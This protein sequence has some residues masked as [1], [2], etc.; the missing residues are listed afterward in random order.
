MPVHHPGSHS[1]GAPASRVLGSGRARRLCWRGGGR[2]VPL[3]GVPG[4]YWVSW[5]YLTYTAAGGVYGMWDVDD[6]PRD[7]RAAL[8][9][10]FV[11]VAAS[12]AMYKAAAVLGG[13][14]PS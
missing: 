4:R 1:G 9:L 13:T 7:G 14:T 11:L 2:E 5:V 6:W 3:S 8:A 10:G 12:Y